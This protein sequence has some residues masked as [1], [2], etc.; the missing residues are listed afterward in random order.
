VPGVFESFDPFDEKTRARVEENIAKRVPD[1]AADPL[2]IGY[3]I[4]NEPRFDEIPKNVPALNGKHACKQHA[5]KRRLVQMLAEK[6]KTIEAFNTVWEAQAK[7]FDELANAGLAVKTAAAYADMKDYTG[8]YLDAYFALVSAAYRKCDPTHLLIG[9]RYQP[10]TINDE[11]LC[12]ITG[13]Y[14][15]VM[16]FNYY[17]YGIE[18]DLLQNIY[19]WS[20]HKPVMLSEFF[21]SSPRDS[22]LVGGREVKSQ[23]ERGLAYRN[24][25]E[26]SAALGFVIGIE[27]FTLVDQSVTGR[28]FSKYSGE[29][30]NTGL[31]SV[32]DRPWKAMLAEM[33]KTNYEIYDVLLGTR[34]PFAWNDPRF[35][36]GG[37]AQ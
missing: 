29:S 18:K 35:Q 25:V 15:D 3:F 11:Q 22:G 4:V 9:A 13:Q 10:I 24:Y 28:W 36:P 12:R 21:W 7:A 31:L 6:Y 23:Q 1:R 14:C 2:L 34:A 17:T 27:W 33:L 20:G 26:Q 32:A 5:C 16:S 37:A 30:A 8:L 19:Q